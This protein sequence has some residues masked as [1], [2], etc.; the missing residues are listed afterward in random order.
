LKH[1]ESTLKLSYSP[2][3]VFEFDSYRE[4]Q[5]IY[6]F[7][8]ATSIYIIARRKLPIMKLIDG[9]LNGFHI[10]VTMNNN[11]PDIEIQMFQKDNI[12]L[13]HDG[14]IAIDKGNNTESKDEFHSIRLLGKNERFIMSANLDRLI[15]LHSN[16]IINLR[17]HGDITPFVTY[18]VLY[19]GQCTDEHI[20]KRFKSHHA[21][22]NILINEKI[23]PPNYD[24]VNDLIIMPFNIES[25]IISELTGD[26]SEEDFIEALTG[27]FSFDHKTISLD[28]EKA[29]IKAMNP[30]Y[31][32]QKFKQYPK[33]KDGLY[34]QHIENI[35]YKIE[36]N[37]ILDYGDDNKIYGAMNPKDGSIIAIQENNDFLIY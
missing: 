13:L 22:M 35:T 28:C 3:T 4:D 8:R 29:L 27:Q 32:K 2:M 14:L 37:I 6:N 15:H 21:L 23:I 20:L 34:N 36:E 5:D 31:N 1:L 30:K 19:V 7:L 11:S 26:S 25:N 24:K 12:E 18:E 10:S 16:K 33:S 9:S 17:I